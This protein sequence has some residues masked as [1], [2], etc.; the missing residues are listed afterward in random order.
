MQMADAKRQ[1]TPLPGTWLGSGTRA[2]LA[3]DH[4]LLQRRSFYVESYRRFCLAD[5]QAFIVRKTA[6]GA[7]WSVVLASAIGLVMLMSAVRAD[8]RPAVAACPGLLVLLL[9]NVWLGP[10]CRFHIRTA[11]SLYRMPMLPRMR[12]AEKF[13]RVLVPIVNE[14]QGQVS[15]DEV[16][17]QVLERDASASPGGAWPDGR[18]PRAIRHCGGA[19]HVGLFSLMLAGA[20]L[21]ALEYFQ[22]TTPVAVLLGILLLA[23]AAFAIAAAIKQADSDAPAGL[24][25]VV[26]LTVAYL[27]V[28]YLLLIGFLVTPMDY[29]PALDLTGRSDFAPYAAFITLCSGALG[30][31]GAVLLAKFRSDYR[32]RLAAEA[33]ILLERA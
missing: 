23:Q 25:A 27:C 26:W 5:I 21:S 3:G 32:R 28:A 24:K 14:A 2:W 6:D 31:L 8:P 15:G 9:V 13:L 11:A 20:V 19:M 29:D 30:L 12:V 22:H 7:I 1:H 10:T 17:R 16:R 33:P 18:V 4:L